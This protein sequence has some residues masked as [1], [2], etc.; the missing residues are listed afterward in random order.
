MDSIG[1]LEICGDRSL[2]INPNCPVYKARDSIVLGCDRLSPITSIA[3]RLK[4]LM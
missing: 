2:P 1:G 3:G 4:D